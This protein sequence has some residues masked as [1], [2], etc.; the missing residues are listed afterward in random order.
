VENRVTIDVRR[1][2]RSIAEAQE[3]VAVAEL[4]QAAARDKL[5][6]LT[7]QYEQQSTLLQNVLDAVSDL[8]KANNV[9]NRAILSVWKA[10]AE[11]QRAVGEL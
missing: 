5:R 4:S 10:Q 9:Y 7:N 3:E 11:L 1:S 8:D 6:V 2:Y